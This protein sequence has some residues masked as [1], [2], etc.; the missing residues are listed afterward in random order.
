MADIDTAL[1]E[2]KQEE[3]TIIELHALQDEEEKIDKEIKEETENLMNLLNDVQPNIFTAMLLVGQTLVNSQIQSR[4]DLFDKKID[5]LQEK[6]TQ[7]QE[8]MNNINKTQ[9]INIARKSLK[10]LKDQISTIKVNQFDAIVSNLQNTANKDVDFANIYPFMDEMQKDSGLDVSDV[11]DAI[12][13]LLGIETNDEK[14]EFLDKV[15]NANG[16]AIIELEKITNEDLQTQTQDQKNQ[17]RLKQ[18]LR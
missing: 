4:N 16:E 2:A 11:K 3:L 1:D 12:K 5:S 10:D 13:Y 7:L 18:E 15:V 14:I 17:Q 6:K 9:D 8:K